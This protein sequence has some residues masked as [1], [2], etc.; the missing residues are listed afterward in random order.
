[1]RGSCISVYLH[2]AAQQCIFKR[3]CR[4]LRRILDSQRR[5][6]PLRRRRTPC[7][8]HQAAR[9][10]LQSGMRSLAR[11]RHR[12]RILK[13]VVLN[14]RRPLRHRCA[15]FRRI[16]R[17]CQLHRVIRKRQSGDWRAIAPLQVVPGPCSSVRLAQ[18]EA[19]IAHHV[20]FTER[21]PACTTC[22]ARSSSTSMA[23]GSVFTSCEV[24]CTSGFPEGD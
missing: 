7:P 20:A 5:M 8:H 9:A 18:V 24:G 2:S 11:L 16:G 10:P 19:V 23:R 15:G 1:M 21:T 17:Q 14:V 6:Q 13:R 12:H 3:R 22:C 4:K